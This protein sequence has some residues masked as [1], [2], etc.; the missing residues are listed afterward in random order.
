MFHFN[1]L[2]FKIE[3][4]SLMLNDSMHRMWVSQ[5]ETRIYIKE[6]YSTL[7]EFS[8]TIGYVPLSNV[9]YKKLIAITALCFY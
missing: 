5:N 3:S 2:H 9:D 4:L 6:R 8:L 7:G 1:L